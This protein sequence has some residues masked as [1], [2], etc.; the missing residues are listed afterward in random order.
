MRV[1]VVDDDH[2]FRK[3]LSRALIRR[4]YDVWSAEGGK[5]AINIVEDKSFDV[6]YCGFKDAGDGWHTGD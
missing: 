3:H 6:A 4:G 1:L 5:D 2:A